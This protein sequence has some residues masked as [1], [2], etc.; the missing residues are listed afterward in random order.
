MFFL[1]DV[2]GWRWRAIGRDRENDPELEAKNKFQAELS[3]WTQ[4]MENGANQPTYDGFWWKLGLSAEEHYLFDP[5]DYYLGQNWT[6][7]SQQEA[8]SKNLL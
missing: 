5:T 3:K 1:C 7:F 4:K 8:L 6:I 2:C